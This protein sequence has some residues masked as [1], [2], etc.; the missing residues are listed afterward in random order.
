MASDHL[1][2]SFLLRLRIIVLALGEVPELGWW[3]SQFISRVGIS[4]LNRMYP[5][6]DFAAAVRSALRAAKPVHDVSI[7]VGHT[8]HLFRLPGDLERKMDFL[9]RDQ[10]AEL[11]T[12]F[13][14]VLGQ[15]DQ[16]L[17]EL[18]MMGDFAQQS[19]SA[20]TGPVRLGSLADIR[21]S[22]LPTR[23]AGTYYAAFRD[24]VRVYPY[25]AGESKRA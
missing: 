21:R 23:L 16:L 7:G 15:R 19:A 8:A 25:F 6:S 2:T 1:D 14:N 5:R 9:L 22:D 17:Q 12:S 24:G 20:V 13:A 10:S 18:S 3:K 11:H 4:Y